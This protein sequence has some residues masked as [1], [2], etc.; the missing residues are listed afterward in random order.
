MSIEMPAA[1]S[2][3]DISMTAM[4]Y[5]PMPI[6][7]L[8]QYKTVVLANESMGRL[9]GI[10][11]ISADPSSDHSQPLVVNDVLRDTPVRA[12]GIDLLQG[13]SPV[14]VT[15]DDF[16]DS[17]V[18][19]A[20][21]ETVQ[22]SEDARTPKANDPQTSSHSIGA[23]P[24]L[25]TVHD[26]AVDVVFS[27]RRDPAT[28]LPL[29][30]TGDIRANA[31][32][33]AQAHQT[34]FEAIMI[35]S[36]W[37]LDDAQYFTLTFTSAAE[38]GL[39]TSATPRSVPK[40]SRN[41]AS[42]LGSGS[43]SSSSSGSRPGRASTASSPK[44]RSPYRMLTNGPATA[45]HGN[46]STL[47]SK[48]HR[49]KDAVLNTIP[50]PTYAIWKDESFGLPN[51]AAL[52]LLGG[53]A[54][55][56]DSQEDS[57][58]QRDLLQRYHLYT[59]DFKT[60]L[61][62]ED[63]PIMK[64]MKSQQKFTNYRVGMHL[65]DT[66]ERL[67]F[68]TDGETICDERTGEFL[69]ALVIFKDVTDII[70]AHKAQ[71]EQQFEDICNMIPVMIWTT[72]ETGAH[73]YYNQKWYDYTGLSHEQSMGDGWMNAFQEDDLAIAAAKFVHCLAT[74]DEYKTE[75]RCRAKDGSYRWMIGQARPLRDESGKILK[76]FGT[77]TDSH[78][79]IV[80][81][82]AAKQTRE[83]LLRVVDHANITLWAVDRDR[84]LSLLEGEALRD[85]GHKVDENSQHLGKNVMNWFKEILET[86]DDQTWIE[87]PINKILS[88]EST[89]EL[90]E[91]EIAQ[92]NQW[93]R[94]R[95]V[96]LYRR[97]LIAGLTGKTE[98]DGV[99]GVSMNVTEVKKR[100][101]ELRDRDIENDKLV[102]QSEAAKEASKM[103][104]QFLA[105]MSHEIRTPIAGVIGM[106]ELLLDD[107]DAPLTADQRECAENL[108]RSANGLLTVINDI[109]DISRVESGRLEVEEV[110]FELNIVVQDVN[111]MLG[112]AAERKGLTFVD[113]TRELQRLKVMGD[114]G[115]LRQILTNLLAN[116]IKFTSEGSVTMIVK[117]LEETAEKVIV[118][119][120]VQD[121][122]IG[123]EEDVKA[124]LFQPFSQAD[125]STARRF[126]GTGLGLTISKN[127]VEL[128]HGE[129]ELQ[130]ILGT[131][132]TASFFVPFNRPAYGA[133]ETVML[134]GPA[135]DRLQSEVSMPDYAMPSAPASP[136][137]QR[138]LRRPSSTV[139][140]GSG[141]AG[142]S[143]DLASITD[144]DRRQ[145]HILV[146]EDNPINQQIA[147]K[148]IKKLKYS[149][150]A[151]WNGQEALDYLQSTDDEE[152]PRPDIILMDVQMP[153]LDG[154][155]A[156]CILRSEQPY[157]HIRET[158]IIAMTASAIHGDREKCEDAGMND[159]L[160][161]PVKGKV[162][163][164][165][166]LKWTLKVR[167]RRDAQKTLPLSYR[168]LQAAK[169]QTPASRDTITTS[170]A[171]S[172]SFGDSP[173]GTKRCGSPATPGHRQYVGLSA[174]KLT[175]MDYSSESLPS[176]NTPAGSAMRTLKNDEMAQHLRDD[177]L[178][179]SA[180][181]THRPTTLSHRLSSNKESSSSSAP[182]R[183]AADSHDGSSGKNTQPVSPS[184]IPG[185][186]QELTE[187]NV[188]RW[189][190]SHAGREREEEASDDQ[191][192]RSNVTLGDQS[193]FTQ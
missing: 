65:T 163:E 97:E 185:G 143:A 139:G 152:H 116:S 52:E 149:V 32:A 93:Y 145:T 151:V 190:R 76:W 126:G 155:K 177:Q 35:I 131:G 133:G 46:G 88:G 101:A 137:K 156:T 158:P 55:G 191:A 154:Y 125:S 136:G 94:T 157:V 59:P 159:Y 160:A 104:S 74:G 69:G 57:L 110:P 36:A 105:N 182:T 168:T 89:D 78:E 87:Q 11:D 102:A 118:Q 173:G 148:T 12:L 128:M 38:S 67:I 130:S 58:T 138:D 37:S 144:E 117:I 141:Y 91:I 90:V 172:I 33:L 82:E 50:M 26:V 48:S 21:G 106:A 51:K 77:C 186:K 61:T 109:L 6:M 100:E 8:S 45:S 18:A 66:D 86:K 20:S 5:L 70:T 99:V 98:V 176:T 187:A 112:F 171:A 9:L 73:D 92:S 60:Q 164:E 140:L 14:W 122:G 129:I 72:T 29:A 167:D 22:S 103:K 80:A 150:H 15:W 1:Q 40:L 56:E 135:P 47:L 181:T 44:A 31:D 113:G 169:A 183:T 25:A 124:R 175:K 83:Q 192:P 53:N 81:R 23:S 189:G 146:V 19:D 114:P 123:I 16:L 178:L 10:D 17:I 13:G 161:K 3:L 120:I 71:N 64:I 107:G 170:N 24:Q 30:T 39:K 2:A 63:Y 85:D 43:L 153:V 28:G 108:Q 121:T 42:G 134:S 7:V 132:T 95:F 68:D 96:P 119:F 84:N 54:P 41:F 180:T 193:R 142:P 174:S 111:K 162:L 127:L 188:A 27:T 75:Y 4:Q 179:Q 49:M 34:Q 166:L 147:I 115:R 79:V 62:I 165:M 184:T